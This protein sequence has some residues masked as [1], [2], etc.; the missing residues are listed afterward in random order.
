MSSSVKV[1]VK[2]L[3]NVEEDAFMVDWYDGM[4]ICA[5]KNVI[6][7]V[8][9]LPVA[10][11][12]KVYPSCDKNA[13]SIAPDIEVKMPQGGEIGASANRPYFYSLGN[14]CYICC[15]PHDPSCVS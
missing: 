9:G 12:R 2:E 15:I 5:L 11:V 1:W 3:A 10:G 13:K 8:S 4:N 14:W 6:V 7:A